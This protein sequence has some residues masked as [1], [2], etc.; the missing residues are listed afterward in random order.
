MNNWSRSLLSFASKSNTTCLRWRGPYAEKKR[1]E[2]RRSPYSLANTARYRSAA[3]FPTP[4]GEM[5]TVGSSSLIGTR[6]AFPYTAADDAKTMRPG[7]CDRRNASSSRNV[8]AK[9]VSQS[10]DGDSTD[11]GTYALAAKWNTTSVQFWE[12]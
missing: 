7:H 10:N 2:A 5:G 1:T 4:Y 9:L 12:K 6:T 8:A 3:S 11:G